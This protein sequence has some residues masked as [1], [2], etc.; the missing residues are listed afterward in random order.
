MKA[1]KEAE[2]NSF[3][4]KY[5]FKLYDEMTKKETLFAKEKKVKGKK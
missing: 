3:L 5:L 2:Y 4:S 1:I